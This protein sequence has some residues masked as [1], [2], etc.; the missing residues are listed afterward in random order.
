V[1]F[2]GQ[3]FEASGA[4]TVVYNPDTD[5]EEVGEYSANYWSAG[6]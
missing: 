6:G 2:Y 4:L 3:H 5:Y 1:P